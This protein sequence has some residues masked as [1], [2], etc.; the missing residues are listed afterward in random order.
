VHA[1]FTAAQAKDLV[2]QAMK[3]SEDMVAA[4]TG[5]PTLLQG[6]SALALTVHLHARVA[7]EGSQL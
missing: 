3:P 6:E 5:N 7:A 4:V 1:Y 2:L